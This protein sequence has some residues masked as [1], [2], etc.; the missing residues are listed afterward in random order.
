MIERLESLPANRRKRDVVSAEQGR[1]VL[2]VSGDR[3]PEVTLLLRESHELVQCRWVG[4]PIILLGLREAR[5]EQHAEDC[6]T[7]GGRWGMDSYA[8]HA[9]GSGLMG[10]VCGEFRLDR[11]RLAARQTCSDSDPDRKP[12]RTGRRTPPGKAPRGRR[13]G[14]LGLLSFDG[15]QLAGPPLATS[16][17]I[18]QDPSS[19]CWLSPMY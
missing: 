7:D 11:V 8:S 18:F 19:C 5:E 3:D 1:S 17:W 6:S 9:P 14:V 16:Q 12:L 10:R 13:A 2:G 15:P 4:A